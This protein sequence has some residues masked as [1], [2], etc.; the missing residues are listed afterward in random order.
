MN[1]AIKGML[2]TTR[3]GKQLRPPCKSDTAAPPTWRSPGEHIRYSW[4]KLFVARQ[5][6]S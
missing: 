4:A 1:N 2:F 6:A 5:A 3:N